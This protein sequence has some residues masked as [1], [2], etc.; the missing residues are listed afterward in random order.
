MP[1]LP[2]MVASDNG[3]DGCH[4]TRQERWRQRVRRA[5]PAA[6]WEKRGTVSEKF[7]KDES[8]PSTKTV[9]SLVSLAGIINDLDLLE[10]V[11]GGKPSVDCIGTASSSDDGPGGVPSFS[12]DDNRIF[13]RASLEVD[14][15]RRGGGG[16]GTYIP[17]G[18]KRASPVTESFSLGC[19]TVDI[20][21]DTGA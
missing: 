10:S 2:M 14:V 21:F 11:N 3:S 1:L 17:N 8:P 16:E 19:D 15:P 4:P 6:R 9:V 5:I 20:E 18:I 12:L 7:C 13:H